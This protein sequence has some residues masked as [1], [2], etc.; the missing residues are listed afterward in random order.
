[1]LRDVR[2]LP[3]AHTLS[4]SEE[5]LQVR[6]YW[7]FEYAE[8]GASAPNEGELV[9]TLQAAM[10]DAVKRRLPVGQMGALYLSGGL[11]S[12]A[13]AAAARTL[14]RKLPSYTISFDDEPHPESPFAGRVARLLGLEHHVVVVG[15]AQIARS[16][17]TLVRGLGQ[18][19]G[20]PSALLQ[21]LLAQE[22]GQSVR[23]A[24][25]G[26]GSVELF[27]GRMLANLA[28]DYRNAQ[29]LKR[30]PNPARQVVRRP[31]V[32]FHRP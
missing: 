17:E 26:D 31:F 2:S 3:A 8:P 30:L 7:Q 13:I 20:N 18:P 23:V 9:E 19:V 22:V 28:R 4:I 27:G 16:F 6:R 1:M 24:F 5:R 15:T 25:S 11:G 32:L 21:V 12:T 14:R 10:N 29:R